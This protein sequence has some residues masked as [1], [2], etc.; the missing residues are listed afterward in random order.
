MGVYLL[1]RSKSSAPVRLE[2]KLVVSGGDSTRVYLL[3]SFV[4]HHGERASGGHYTAFVRVPAPEARDNVAEGDQEE[5]PAQSSAPDQDWWYHID[6][7]VVTLVPADR[8]PL[9]SPSVYVL[10]YEAAR[11]QGGADR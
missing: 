7:A 4:C 3:R 5:Q 1:S 10:L 6:D 2:Q 8:L 11:A 9:A